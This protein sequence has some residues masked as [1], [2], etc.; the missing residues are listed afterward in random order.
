MLRNDGK[1]TIINIKTYLQTYPETWIKSNLT[2]SHIIHI[3][4]LLSHPYTWRLFEYCSGVFCFSFL[5]ELPSPRTAQ[6]ELR[7]GRHCAWSHVQSLRVASRNSP[8]AA[9]KHVNI[10]PE[11]W[12]IPKIHEKIQKIQYCQI[13]LFTLPK[14]VNCCGK[15]NYS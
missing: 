5:R 8:C 10:V 14:P 12:K 7:D 15:E 4:W 9:H 2:T 13:L 11:I 3:R 6:W 1:T